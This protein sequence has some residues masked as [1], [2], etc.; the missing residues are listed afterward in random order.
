M[1]RV[2]GRPDWWELLTQAGSEAAA[3]KPASRSLLAA[4]ALDVHEADGGKACGAHRGDGM[5]HSSDEG[6][7]V[8][9][10]RV[11]D[12][13]LLEGREAGACSEMLALLTSLVA[14]APPHV[15]LKCK[16][17]VLKVVQEAAWSREA[18]LRAS[19]QALVSEWLAALLAVRP[20]LAPCCEQPA[21][22]ESGAGAEGAA[23]PAA[24]AAAVMWVLP[25]LE[26]RRTVQEVVD[27]LS[28]QAFEALD[29]TGGFP[30][31]EAAAAIKL[32]GTSRQ[33]AALGLLRAVMRGAGP[34]LSRESW[35]SEQPAHLD[36]CRAS[37]ADMPGLGERG[38]CEGGGEGGLQNTRGIAR[39]SDMW[40]R[41][42]SAG[43]S[44]ADAGMEWLSTGWRC[45]VQAGRWSQGR[46]H[47]VQR[48]VHFEAQTL[49]S[50]WDDQWADGLCAGAGSSVSFSCSYL[51]D[52][53]WRSGLDGLRLSG[54]CG[55]SLP[56][57]GRWLW[58][59][60][61]AGR[62][63]SS[64][65]AGTSGK[66]G[67]EGCDWGRQLVAQVAGCLKAVLPSM[68]DAAVL[69]DWVL[70]AGELLYQPGLL[71]DLAAQ[72][73]R[74][75][76]DLEALSPCP[77][78]GARTSAWTRRPLRAHAAMLSLRFWAYGAY[79]APLKRRPPASLA[80]IS[81]ALQSL[82]LHEAER[83]RHAALS[84]LPLAL[85][86]HPHML[87]ALMADADAYLR[88]RPALCRRERGGEHG[89]RAGRGGEA[90]QA[91]VVLDVLAQPQC[92]V[93]A[94]SDATGLM[95]VFELVGHLSRWPAL[96]SVV[97]GRAAVSRIASAVSRIWRCMSCLWQPACAPPEA[98]A[99]TGALHQ[100]LEQMRQGVARV[101]QL[102]AWSSEDECRRVCLCLSVLWLAGS[103]ETPKLCPGHLTWSCLCLLLATSYRRLSYS[104]ASKQPA[105]A[106]LGGWR[107]GRRR[108]PGRGRGRGGGAACFGA[109]VGGAERQGLDG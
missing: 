21:E 4:I 105:R 65:A 2:M 83:V 43:L 63:A 8:I 107:S 28:R 47:N 15:A 95:Q 34:L 51:T 58:P 11:E 97:A 48:M 10:A 67:G 16:Q 96:D 42:T 100:L 1:Q 81:A 74:T 27:S 73:A 91:M 9:E 68:L 40:A 90:T 50:K 85:Q 56:L 22:I 89:Q 36:S 44:Q 5:L 79:L 76:S 71:V 99:G 46:E 94:L 41:Q 39:A 45:D 106:R 31:Q 80:P 35:P 3:R 14:A 72:C 55:A 66:E 25:S 54:A 17:V 78:A 101:C 19:A 12:E 61:G 92:L 59:A 7:D 53:C 13:L 20:N 98:P 38:V 52:G 93:R 18:C 109:Q 23:R 26:C 87:P 69:A 77:S 88:S 103:S 33:A 24:A 82:C 60:V 104:R 70:L 6:E 84:L 86:L 32:D 57:G 75:A 64:G 102:E 108:R 49:D 29:I 62:G 37:D 30:S